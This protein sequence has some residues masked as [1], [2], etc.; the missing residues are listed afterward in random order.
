MDFFK[1]LDDIRSSFRRFAK[2]LPQDGTLII[3]GEIENYAGITEGILCPY[4]TYGF[5]FWSSHKLD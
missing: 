3:N 2:L 4:I 1:D 5:S